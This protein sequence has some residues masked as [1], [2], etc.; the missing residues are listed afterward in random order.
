[1]LVPLLNSNV[2]YAYYNAIDV[3][4]KGLET[5]DLGLLVLVGKLFHKAICSFTLNLSS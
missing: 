3:L 1:M 5:S 4:A 2:K